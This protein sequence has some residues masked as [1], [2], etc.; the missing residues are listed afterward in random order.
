MAHMFAKARERLSSLLISKFCDL[1]NIFILMLAR[2]KDFF[3]FFNL[4]DL[5]RRGKDVL[6]LKVLMIGVWG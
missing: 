6:R 1:T 2:K 4:S 3:R 5:C